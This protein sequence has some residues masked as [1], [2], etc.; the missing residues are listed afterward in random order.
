MARAGDAADLD[1]AMADRA[2]VMAERVATL[3][4]THVLP[5][6]DVRFGRRVPDGSVGGAIEW[7]GR[8]V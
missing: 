3:N 2:R 6:R 1:G 4:R 5:Q 8:A 7:G